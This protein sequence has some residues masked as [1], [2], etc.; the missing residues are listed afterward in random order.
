MDILNSKGLEIIK[1]Q[2]NSF[3]KEKGGMIGGGRGDNFD[4]HE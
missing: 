2:L 4:N 3:F 1:Q